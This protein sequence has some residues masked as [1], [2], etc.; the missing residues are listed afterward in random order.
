[1]KPPASPSSNAV[2]YSV[3]CIDTTVVVCV[4]LCS[5]VQVYQHFGI[6][7]VN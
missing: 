5:F 1:M 7:Q 2:E 4:M 3:V 6:A